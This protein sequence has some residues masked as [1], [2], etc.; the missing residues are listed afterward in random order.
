MAA[1]KPG[2][3]FLYQGT[4]VRIIRLLDLDKIEIEDQ[5]KKPHLVSRKSLLPVPE[6]FEV[7]DSNEIFLLSEKDFELATKRYNIILPMIASP[8]DGEIVKQVSAKH[9]IPTTT[10]YRWA[11]AY[12]E[13]GSIE[14]LAEGRGKSLEGR[15]LIDPILEKIVSDAIDKTYLT[16]TRKSITKV[17]E[18]VALQ[19]K[20]RKLSPPHTNTI[21]SRIHGI[22]QREALGKRK[23]E[24]K[25]RDSYDPRT[26]EFP[27][28]VH[29][30]QVVQIDHTP[31]DII[32]VDPIHNLPIKGRPVLTTALDVVT[33]MIVGYYLSFFK[34][35]FTSAGLC[36]A[37]AIL[38]KD[39]TLDKLKISG[40]W[41]CWG[42]MAVLYMDNAKEFRGDSM[43]RACKKHVIH[44]SWR[45]RKNPRFAGHIESFQKTLNQEIH[46]LP[47]STFFSV[48]HRDN[49]DSEKMAAL[50]FE[51]LE[52]YIVNFIVNKYHIRVHPSLK[53]PPI[54]VWKEQIVGDGATIPGIGYQKTP[55]EESVKINFQP[56][57]VRTIQNYGVS[58]EGIT[59]YSNSL[60]PFIKRKEPGRGKK[61]KEY[62]FRWD[63]RDLSSIHLLHPIKKDFERIDLAKIQY[64]NV[65]AN[66][67]EYNA[68][69]RALKEKGIKEVD[70]DRV[71]QALITAN[72][73]EKRAL[74]R[75]A[76]VKV[77]QK[78]AKKQ[79]SESKPKKKPEVDE[80][81]PFAG[82]DLDSIKPY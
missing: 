54:A 11:N 77:D 53:R 80:D 50:T 6:E 39:A 32:V 12:R 58:H 4:L 2:E 56:S 52:A 38:E 51:E 34:P 68:M 9:K 81:D 28:P 20:K 47:G 19:C 59:Y 10:L 79:N 75:K 76:Q 17:I 1:I 29:A 33:R 13:G 40:D 8:G 18:E 46:N 15:K 64:R 44:T 71:F 70:E 57:F 65:K 73:I 3:K 27:N 5:Y 25:A 62:E 63:P 36:V 82:M 24:E 16:S 72:E 48:K 42:T 7:K 74:D 14:S 43:A 45:P 49:Y 31:V 60:K 55:K 66:I 26:G 61:L 41:P 37:H 21:R 30:L 22:D 67:W 23:G 78:K 35:G 69:M